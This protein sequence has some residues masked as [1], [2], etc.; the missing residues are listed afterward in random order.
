MNIDK[1]KGKI[2]SK[3]NEN[4]LKVQ[5]MWDKYF[6]DHF[7]IRLSKSKENMNFILK[8]GFLLENIVGIKNRTT[9]DLDFSYRLEDINEEEVKNKIIN[10]L[11]IEVDDDIDYDFL[12]ISPITEDKGGRSGYRV[13][14]NATTGNIKKKFGIDI[15]CGDVITP[16]AIKTTYTTNITEEEIEIYSYNKETILAEK[17]QSIIAKNINNSRMK[18]FY[19]IYILINHKDINKELLHDVI[20]NTFD[21]RDTPIQKEYIKSEL[22]K[23]INSGLMELQFNKFITKSKL[24]IKITYKEAC[25]AL[26]EVFQLIQYK[27]PFRLKINNLIIIRHGEDEQDKLGG[28]SDNQ[29]TN[30]GVN[31]MK[32]LKDELVDILMQLDSFAIIS[33]DLARAKE[34]AEILFKDKYKIN[35]DTSLRECNNGDLKNMTIKEFKEKYPNMYFSNLNYNQKYPSGESPKE[36]YERISG[37]IIE[38]NELYSEKNLIIVTH[39]GFY[40]VFKSM[41]DGIKWTNKLKHKLGYGEYIYIK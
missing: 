6:F 9:L 15:V 18:D 27:D 14:L 13:R 33:S 20:V 12:D 8:G 5:E 21:N 41:L 3:A 1:L 10:I 32:K 11:N 28:W 16:N 24:D 36:F 39:K 22:D 2:K 7:L 4:N 37:L 17:F 30:N 35:Y 23:I 29:L 25:D 40:S 31:Q 19:D 26:L 38:L 34:S